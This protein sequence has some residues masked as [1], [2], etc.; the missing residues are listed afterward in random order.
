MITFWFD[1]CTEPVNPG[2]HSAYGLLIR[3]NRKTIL[4][5]SG[6]LGS[7]EGITN[8]VA[9]YAGF[10]NALEFLISKKLTDKKIRCFGDSRLVILQQFGH[11]KIRG[12]AYVSLA[13]KAKKKLLPQFKDIFGKWIPRDENFRADMLSKK[14]LHEKGVKFKLQPE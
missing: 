7:G 13:L 4:A 5:E 3:S 8:N 11:W 1:G 14:V 9:E 10:V 6:Y 12:G 2:G